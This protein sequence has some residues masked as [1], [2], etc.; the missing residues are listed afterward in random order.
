MRV[1]SAIGSGSR[2][3]GVGGRRAPT[4]RTGVVAS[5]VAVLAV[6]GCALAPNGPVRD[7]GARPPSPAGAAGSSSSRRV[8]PPPPRT[9]TTPSPTGFSTVVAVACN[10]RPTGAQVVALLRRDGVLPAQ[11][12][13]TVTNGPLCAG[14]WQYTEISMSGSEPIDVVTRGRP[15]ALDLVTAGTDVCT[16]GVRA[17]APLGIRTLLR[18]DTTT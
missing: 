12:Q 18:C 10:G 13:A 4:L 2:C 17:A 1:A 11:A 15:E 8:P 6:A 9:T 7:P 5:M 16:K 3:G 14:T